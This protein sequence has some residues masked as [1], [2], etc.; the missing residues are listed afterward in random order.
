MNIQRN[1][2]VHQIFLLSVSYIGS[3]SITVLPQFKVKCN[4]NKNVNCSGVRKNH[5]DIDM[6]NINIF[7][8]ETLN[9]ANDLESR[10]CH[11]LMCQ[12][13]STHYDNSDTTYLLLAL[14][15]WRFQWSNHLLPVFQPSIC[16]LFT[17][18]TSLEPRDKI[19]L[20]LIECLK[21]LKIFLSELQYFIF[22]SDYY[23]SI[24]R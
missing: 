5:M 11:N 14:L 16:K 17:F 18:L 7:L 19:E 23:L 3:A 10:S 13:E 15:N 6:K 9:L 4:P 21:M 24:L 12:V 2:K 22:F 8:S 1:F 20:N